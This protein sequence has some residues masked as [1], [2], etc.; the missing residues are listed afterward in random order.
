[1]PHIE[2]EPAVFTHGIHI[3]LISEYGCLNVDDDTY[4]Y[5]MACGLYSNF[6]NE[7]LAEYS[8]EL[9]FILDEFIEH[10]DLS[11][12]DQDHLL[13]LFDKGMKFVE[14]FNIAVEELN[15]QGNEKLN[16]IRIGENN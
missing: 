3:R 5:S 4:D 15:R 13:Y 10:Y 11:T 7:E 6:Y 12:I 14:F 16:N 9:I 2:F 8:N 1:M